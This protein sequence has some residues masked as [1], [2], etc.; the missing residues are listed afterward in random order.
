MVA[1][2]RVEKRLSSSQKRGKTDRHSY[3]L[4]HELL[5]EGPLTITE[6]ASIIELAMTLRSTRITDLAARYVGEGM[7]IAT[8]FHRACSEVSCAPQAKKLALTLW[9]RTLADRAVAVQ[10]ASA[11]PNPEEQAA[12]NLLQAAEMMPADDALIIRTAAQLLSN[13]KE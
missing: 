4:A 9:A 6:R 11:T 7:G 10:R 3:E 5:S 2:G 12:R 13:T 1:H 8:A